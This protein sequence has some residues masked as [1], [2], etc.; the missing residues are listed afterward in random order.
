MMLPLKHPQ[1]RTLSR[2]LN[3]QQYTLVRKIYHEEQ[4]RVQPSYCP[5]DSGSLLFVL[6]LE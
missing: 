6:A 1:A 4:E 3:L 2:G 5:T